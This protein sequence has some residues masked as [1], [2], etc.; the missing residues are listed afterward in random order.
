[1]SA[2][3]KVGIFLLRQHFPPFRAFTGEKKKEKKGRLNVTTTTSR[4]VSWLATGNYYLQSVSDYLHHSERIFK[5]HLDLVLKTERCLYSAQIAIPTT[6]TERTGVRSFFQRSKFP[7]KNGKVKVD[8]K[9]ENKARFF[10][11]QPVERE[12]KRKSLLAFMY[13][14]PLYRRRAKKSAGNNRTSAQIRRF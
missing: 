10:G 7:K 6:S 11:K 12:R 1:M 8:K 9:N 5:E 4:A 14:A 13:V 2:N 3:T